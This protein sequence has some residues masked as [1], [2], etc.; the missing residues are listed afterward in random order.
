MMSF[1]RDRDQTKASNTEIEMVKTNP[2][3]APLGLDHEQ[4]LPLSQEPKYTVVNG[5]IANRLS[6]EPIPDDEPVFI[7]RGKDV[8]A[9]QALTAYA[10]LVGAGEHRE[11]VNQRAAQF[12]EFARKNP[13]RMKKPDT[14]RD[15]IPPWE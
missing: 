13:A 12:A 4:G 10:S 6:G 2:A 14:S 5:R 9:H 11:A 7:L 3:Q 8:H 1:E 15:N